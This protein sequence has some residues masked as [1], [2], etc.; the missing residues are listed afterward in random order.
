MSQEQIRDFIRLCAENDLKND[1]LLRDYTYVSGRWCV[2]STARD[3]AVDG[4]KNLRRVGDLWRTVEKLIAKDDKPLSAKDAQKEDEK[5]QKLIDKRK[6]ESDGERK[7]R[8]EKEEK[9]HEQ[10]R[11]F[12]REVADAYN[13]E[14]IGWSR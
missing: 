8:L 7:K 6:D 14:F 11:Q 3:V 9:D 1:K 2:M 12:V 13:F 5:V 4:N 10:E